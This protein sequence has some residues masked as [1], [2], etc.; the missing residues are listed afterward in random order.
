MKKLFLFLICIAF[1]LPCMAAKKKGKKSSA[2]RP[3]TVNRAQLAITH[4]TLPEPITLADSIIFEAT[5]H[6]GKPYRSG[7]K[8]PNTFD[9]SGF[10]SYVFK[11]LGFNLGNNSRDQY[12]QGIKVSKEHIHK[13]DLVFFTGRDAHAGVGHVGIVYDVAADKKS[14]R[15]IHSSSSKGVSI[16][17]YPDGGYYSK[18]YRGAKRMVDVVSP[19]PLP[20]DNTFY[21]VTPPPSVISLEAE[22]ENTEERTAQVDERHVVKKG[23][24]V[25]SIA[26]KHHVS[27]AQI[28]KWNN[29]KKGAQLKIGQKLIVKPDLQKEAISNERA[30]ESL[31]KAEAERLANSRNITITVKEGENIYLISQKYHCTVRELDYWNN[32]KGDTVKVGQ[33]LVIRPTDIS[34]KKDTIE[35]GEVIHTV[36]KG[37]NIYQIARRY[38]CQTQEIRVWNNLPSNILQPGSR[39]VIKRADKKGVHTVR[40]GETLDILAIKYGVTTEELKEWNHLTHKDIRAGRIIKVSADATSIYNTEDTVKVMPTIADPRKPAEPIAE[41]AGE[42]EAD[43]S[44]ESDIVYVIKKGDT[45]SKISQ[46]Y[47]VSTKQLMEWNNMKTSNIRAGAKLI[48]QKGSK[49]TQVKKEAEPILSNNNAKPTKKETTKPETRNMAV[50]G[51]YTVKSGDNLYNISRRH[52]CTVK[53]LMEWNN[54]KNDKLRLNQKLIIKQ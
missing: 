8:G 26:K 45:F 43:N 10:T 12:Q 28:Q 7:S 51:I 29:L 36:A 42:A 20:I 15:F 49:K 5:R 21:N 27:A 17:R 40:E 54:L 33:E 25:Y 48:I 38:N 39:L 53:Q 19:S 11:Q 22:E 32:L 2:R 16:A 44:Q 50:D 52:H 24:N 41:K 34:A 6:M 14:F 4:D 46:K 35:N 31:A 30:Q 47:G 23:E 3:H 9:C 37:E 18:R 1:V 13:G